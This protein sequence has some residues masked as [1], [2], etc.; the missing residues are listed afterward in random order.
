MNKPQISKYYL[1]S[2]KD[3]NKID[4]EI[5]SSHER[6]AWI[7]IKD[8]SFSPRFISV[9]TEVEP[10][11]IYKR[12]TGNFYYPVE[13]EMRPEDEDK[14]YFK[15]AQFYDQYTAK[16]NLPMAQFILKKMMDLGVGKD[17]KILDL[18]AGTGIFSNLAA[19]KGFKN[20][21]LVDISKAMLAEAKKKSVLKN[22]EF[23]AI[24]VKSMKLP[25]NYDVIVSI[26]MFDA[27]KNEDLESV[28]DNLKNHLNPNGLFLVVEDRKRPEYLKFFNEIED[29]IFDISK[30]KSFSKY[31]FIGRES[32]N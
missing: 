14:F 25:Q 12:F 29:G 10:E 5:E 31:Y 11:I 28:L 7:H 19:Q 32:S 30:E 2:K 23:I 20:L 24:D 26:M 13:I 18:G 16:N 9:R 8:I 21:T 15:Y 1:E 27:I 22:A 17:K 3:I 6:P 4:F